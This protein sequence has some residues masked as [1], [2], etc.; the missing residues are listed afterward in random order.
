M[1]AATFFVPSRQSEFPVRST[2]IPAKAG[3][4]SSCK[5][6]VPLCRDNIMLT[7]QIDPGEIAPGRNTLM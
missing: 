3:Q 4:F 5:H 7:V 1:F 6:P 2:L